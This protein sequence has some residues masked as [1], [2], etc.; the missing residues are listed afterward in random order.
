LIYSIDKCVFCN[1]NLED[2]IRYYNS[3]SIEKYCN[4]CEHRYNI[5]VGSFDKWV[6]T[7][8]VDGYYFQMFH[9]IYPT[10]MLEIIFPDEERTLSIP[11][12]RLI[13]LDNYLEEIERTIKLQIFK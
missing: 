1:S 8:N 2:N 6:V 9:G 11:E 7:F 4:N 5:G 13:T 3:S 10:D 12:C